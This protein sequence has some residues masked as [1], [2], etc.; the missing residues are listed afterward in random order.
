MQTSHFLRLWCDAVGDRSPAS[1]TPSGRCNHCATQ[2]RS[3]VIGYGF[4]FYLELYYMYLVHHSRPSGRP[5]WYYLLSLQFYTTLYIFITS[6]GLSLNYMHGRPAYPMV[7]YGL[8]GSFNLHLPP[9]VLARGKGGGGVLG[10]GDV[11]SKSAF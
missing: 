8:D 9:A 10:K 1:R 5:V 4:L 11:P 2:G 7:S 6:A 3:N